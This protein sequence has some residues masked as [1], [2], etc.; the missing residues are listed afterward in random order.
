MV[1]W[2]FVVKVGLVVLRE[3]VVAETSVMV[4]VVVVL[5]AVPTVEGDWVAVEAI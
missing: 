2:P 1:V 3:E 5:V 4:V